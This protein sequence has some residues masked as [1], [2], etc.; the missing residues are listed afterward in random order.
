METVA[1]GAPFSLSTSLKIKREAK[2]SLV[3]Y[4]YFYKP[5]TLLC[6]VCKN[7]DITLV[8][9]CQIVIFH[10]WQQFT[11]KIAANSNLALILRHL[12]KKDFIKK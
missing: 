5:F 4:L 3:K 6:W 12:T 2:L 10:Y 11:A 8:V 7:V 9:D 1:F